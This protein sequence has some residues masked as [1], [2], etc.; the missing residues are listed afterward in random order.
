[1]VP[2]TDVEALT[3]AYGREIFARLEGGGTVPF[4]PE[5]WNARLMEW[6]MSDPAVQVQLFRFIDALPLLR[7]PEQ[8]TQHLREYLGA[9][10]AHLPLW[11][12][13]P[14]NWL[15]RNGLAGRLLA[16]T[17]RNSAQRFARRFIAGTNLD[18][19][20]ATIAHLR[21]QRLA[22]TVD[23]LGEATITEREADQY[24]AEYLR[25]IAGLCDSAGYWADVDLIDRDPHGPLPRVNVSIKLSSLYSQFDP[26]DPEGTSAAVRARL[27]PV[28]R[29][30]RSRGA[31]V[32]ID[33]EQYAFKEL[34]LRI[35]REVL[36]E[37]EFRDW[38][39]VGIAIQ[40][41][42]RDCAADLE[43]LAR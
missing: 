28:L 3:Q 13:L 19:A 24:Q 16:G 4:G 6:T 20:L 30:A 36:T 14:L 37:E 21:R 5:W 10:G 26:I 33:M 41:Y 43:A 31:F 32:N 39:D 12:R 17:A 25:L 18:E 2:T 38:P 40:A 15:P 34:T 29:A 7:S 11:L 27:R 42:L 1:M 9:A 22:F 23:L 35:F 8:I